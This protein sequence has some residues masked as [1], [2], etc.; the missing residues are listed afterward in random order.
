MQSEAATSRTLIRLICVDTGTAI[1]IGLGGGKE[2]TAMVAV[3]RGD[4]G[5]LNFVTPAPI[6]ERRK[7]DRW[8]SAGFPRGFPL[9][10][11]LAGGARWDAFPRRQW[12][13]AMPVAVAQMSWARN[14]GKLVTTDVHLT[15][16]A[17]D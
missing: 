14:S 10:T 9:A 3:L 2:R 5:D 15:S 6:A 12:H 8:G 4:D 1:A 13:L 16:N 17:P 11:Y 7:P